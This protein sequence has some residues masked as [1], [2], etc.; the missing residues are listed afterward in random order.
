[1]SLKSHKMGAKFFCSKKGWD[2]YPTQE[3]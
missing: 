1:L 3:Y 2:F